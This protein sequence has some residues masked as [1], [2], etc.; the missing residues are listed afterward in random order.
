MVFIKNNKKIIGATGF[1][2]NIRKLIDVSNILGIKVNH[3]EQ[4]PEKLGETLDWIKNS[5][6][7]DPS[8]KMDFSC[9]ECSDI[10][11]E[12]EKEKG[13]LENQLVNLVVIAGIT[14]SQFI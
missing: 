12:L 3:T 14:P 2:F 9:R 6:I 4:N 5:I 7:K 13:K 11:K 10:L 8:I 1:L